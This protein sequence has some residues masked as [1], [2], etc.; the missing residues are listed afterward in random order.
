MDAIVQGLGF[1]AEPVLFWSAKVDDG[2]WHL[3]YHVNNAI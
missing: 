1:D 2:K 3:D